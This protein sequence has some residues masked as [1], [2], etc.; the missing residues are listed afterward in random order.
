MLERQ[1]R[2]PITETAKEASFI[3]E[4]PG[5]R[6]LEF[7]RD[8]SP[9]KLMKLLA[10]SSDAKPVNMSELVACLDQSKTVLKPN[11]AVLSYIS[12]LKKKL[13]LHDFTIAN[14]EN[15]G[16]ARQRPESRFV[17]R[18]LEPNPVKK[19]TTARQNPKLRERKHGEQQGQKVVQPSKP[20]T[21]G[22]VETSVLP[23]T[24]AQKEQLAIKLTYL[25][26][27]H[28]RHGTIL[29]VEPDV[30]SLIKSNLPERASLSSAVGDNTRE[31]AQELFS[32]L[33][34][35]TLKRLWPQKSAGVK[36]SDAGREA[37]IA[38]SCTVL[39]SRGYDINFVI[40]EVLSHFNIPIPTD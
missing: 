20:D 21:L 15:R 36:S 11:N 38:K 34:I 31:K 28:V 29:K 25:I 10:N 30:M 39:Q 3:V 18:K 17:L 2:V 37:D 22:A 8:G 24:E 26:L 6:N 9:Y 33:F 23:L 4:L 35:A 32:Q 14:L 12:A 1:T 40:K 27:S 5:N 19:K 16:G 7:E 13:K